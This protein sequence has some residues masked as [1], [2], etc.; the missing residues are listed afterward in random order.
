MSTSIGTLQARGRVGLPFLA[1]AILALFA[2]AAIGVYVTSQEAEPATRRGTSNTISS[3]AAN[4]PTE[5]RGGILQAPAGSIARPFGRG[6]VTPK[7]A[8]STT[9]SA[10]VVPHANQLGLNVVIP[11]TA[12]APGTEVIAARN[13]MLGSYQQASAVEVIA[14]RNAMLGSYQPASVDE[15][16]AARNAMLGSYQQALTAEIVAARNA[17]LGSYQEAASDQIVVNGEV[18]QICWKFR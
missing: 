1:G 14:A 3:T 17:M 13:A 12:F 4:T 5:L 11:S 7:V 8:G 15:V 10:I 9:S 2:A 16:I 6:A 18:C